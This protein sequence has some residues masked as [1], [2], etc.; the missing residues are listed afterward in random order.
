VY[1]TLE[2]PLGVFRLAREQGLYNTYVTNG[3]MTPEALELLV[4]SGLDAVNVDVK[5]DAEAVRLWCGADVAKVWRN[6]KLALQEGVWLEITTLVIP[7]I[8]DDD[9]VLRS[10]ASRIVADLGL[11]VPWHI[12]GYS[13]A[14]QFSAPST[15]LRT[16]ERAW[17]IGREEGLR[18]V[19]LGNVQG[20]RLENTYCCECEALLIQRWGLR[21]RERRL[22]QGRCPDCG[23]TVPGVWE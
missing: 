5:G 4:E 10:I 2:W 17:R 21:V 20:H 6:C 11:D 7:G 19:Y 1:R 14:Y 23:R 22:D 8:N 12:S 15:P 3:C 9:G 18:F 13:P 16:L